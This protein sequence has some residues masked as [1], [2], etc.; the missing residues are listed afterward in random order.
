MIRLRNSMTMAIMLLLFLAST[1][2]LAGSSAS[3]R[4]EPPFWWNGMASHELQLMVSAKDVAAMQVE[5]NYPDVVVSEIIQV[6]NPDFLFINLRIGDEATAGRFELRFLKGK[7]QHYVYSYELKERKP[8]SAARRGFD[9]SDVIYLLMPDRFANG[10][11]S[12]DN[13]SWMREKADR[14]NP[15]GRHGG[16]LKG[17]EDHLDYFSELGV[18]TLWLNPVLENNM[19]AYSY[20]GYA[21]TDFYQVDARFGS[22]ED[23]VRLTEKAHNKGLKMVMDMVFN[24]YGT[25]HWWTDNLPM[26]D[27]NNVWPEFTRSNYRGGAIMDPNASEYD[28]NK[29]LKGWFDTSMADLNQ[30]NPYVARYLIQN[31]IWW[32][33]YVG[34]DGIRMDTY[35]YSDKDFM[36]SWMKALK[37][38]YPHFSVVGEVWLNTPPQV[39]YWQ[40][41]TNNGDGFQSQLPY[42]F[43]FPLKYAITDAFNE[44]NGWSSGVAKLYES[45]SVDYLFADPL[46]TVTFADNHDA[47]RIFSRLGEDLNKF[48]MAMGFV[49]TVRGVPQIYYGTEL[50][51]TGLEHEGHGFIRKDFPGGWTGDPASAFTRDGRSDEQ[52]QA[53]DFMSRLIKWR[54]SNRV[55]QTGKTTH[56]IPDDGIYVYFRHDEKASVM[57]ILNNNKSAKKLH[58]ERF[59]ESMNGYAHGVDVISRTVLTSLSTID[60]EPMSVHIIELKRTK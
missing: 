23:Y 14:S 34:L 11:L 9:N 55:V 54:S 6:G 16:D 57:V 22:N 37:A 33:E 46:K 49:L 32:I 51:M 10:N 42:V 59:S 27:W 18:N 1:Q 29:M 56:Y 21:I 4:V 2:L 17:I 19:P 5:L 39:A 36:V 25:S 28:K 35:P 38:E 43:S 47:D 40:D 44:D 20:H 53:W 13:I 52:N 58:T 26:K 41:N 7:K 45:L 12:N 24:H 50:L 48:K 15:N 8:G 60:L 3:I 30:A 31:S